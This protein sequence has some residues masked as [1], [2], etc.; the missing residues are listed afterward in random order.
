MSYKQLIAS[1]LFVAVTVSAHAAGDANAGKDKAGVCFGCHGVNGNSTNPAW[2]KLNGQHA[3][4]IA[5]QLADFKSGDRK[6]PLM[7]GQV[8][9]LSAQDMDDLAAFFTKQSATMGKADKAKVAL[10]EK[11]YRGGN[12]A[13]GVAACIG[14]HGPTGAGNPPAGFPAV[15]GQHAAYMVKALKDFRSGA[16][17]NDLN[18]M[19]R[20]VAS[21]MSD[22]EIEAVASYMSGLH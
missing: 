16:R 22:K 20:N 6:D 12:S 5:K 10:G 15:S 2:P 19:M 17:A 3:K 7:I 18:G 13:K 14:C 8:A 4:Y 9:N 21:K 11:I 1:I